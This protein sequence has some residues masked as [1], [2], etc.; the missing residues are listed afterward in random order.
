MNEVTREPFTRQSL[1]RTTQYELFLQG[2]LHG[3]QRSTD[4][5]IT[6]VSFIYLFP[7]SA[8]RIGPAKEPPPLPAAARGPA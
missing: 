6:S 4:A 7:P 2:V 8:D 1:H 5:H 3:S